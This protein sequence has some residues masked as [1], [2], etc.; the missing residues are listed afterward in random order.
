DGHASGIVIFSQAGI[1]P[2][3]L[4]A[5]L[6]AAGVKCAVRAGG[7]RF[8]PHCYNTIDEIDTAIAALD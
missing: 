8:S 1:D 2:D 4:H 5:R 3:H 6:T 7:I